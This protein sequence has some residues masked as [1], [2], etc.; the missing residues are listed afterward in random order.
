[1]YAPLAK[2]LIGK[3]VGDIAEATHEK[4]DYQID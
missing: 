2:A 1:M 3:G 4:C